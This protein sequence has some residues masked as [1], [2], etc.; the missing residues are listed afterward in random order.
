MAESPTTS[1]MIT[2]FYDGACPQCRR[3]RARYEKLAGI[4][5]VQW[6][7]ITGQQDTLRQRGIDPQAALLQLHV[8]DGQGR[9]HREM[10]AYRL[11]LSQVN[12]L[13]PLAWL[14][15]LPLVR[16][17]LS[18]CLTRWVNRRLRKDGRLPGQSCNTEPPGDR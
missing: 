12:G 14:I 1:G 16:P 11:L 8:E 2:V 13:R 9:L 15:G 6:L 17:L 7:D 4:D 10:D 18:W 3:E 5:R